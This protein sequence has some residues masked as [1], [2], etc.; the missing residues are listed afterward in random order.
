ME[1]PIQNTSANFEKERPSVSYPGIS[2]FIER[3]KSETSPVVS[4]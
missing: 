4:V 2:I 3:S 1:P